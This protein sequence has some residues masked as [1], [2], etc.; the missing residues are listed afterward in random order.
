MSPLFPYPPL[1]RSATTASSACSSSCSFSSNRGGS[2]RCG[3]EPRP[4]SSRGRSRTDAAATHDLHHQENR[5]QG[6]SQV[7]TMKWFRALALLLALVLT[8]AACGGSS[9]DDDDNADADADETTTD[10][11]GD[12]GGEEPARSAEHTSELQSLMRI[13]YAVF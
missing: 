11:G 4:G 8:A 13:S 5:Q 6:D 7:K 3:C 9:D 1:S 2:P 12:D 10:D